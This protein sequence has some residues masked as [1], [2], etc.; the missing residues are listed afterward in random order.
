MEESGGLVS[1]GCQIRFFVLW[2]RT[3]FSPC[4]AVGF[5]GGRRA[6]FSD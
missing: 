1:W 3:N 5:V 4:E 6:L 2:C